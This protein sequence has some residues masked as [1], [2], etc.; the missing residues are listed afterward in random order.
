MFLISVIALCAIPLFWA[1]AA[2]AKLRVLCGSSMA[3]PMKKVVDAF[4]RETGFG[5][6]LT[7]G[8]CEALLPQVELGAPADVF[9]GHAPFAGLLKEKG[10]RADRLVVLGAL[11][12][13]LVVAKGNPKG[14]RGVRDLARADVR[15]GLPDARYSTCG[16][17]FEA[18][19]AK[20]NL[21]DGIRARTV[22]TSRAHQELATTLRTGNVD[23]VIVWNFIAA[24]HRE[25]FEVVPMELSFPSAEVFATV[26]KKAENV[27]AA[28]RLLDYLDTDAAKKVFVD[29]GYGAGDAAATLRLYCAAGVQKPVDELV[30]VFKERHPG[31][32]VEAVYQGS[33]ALLAQMG[34]TKQGD[35]YVAGDEFFMDQARSKGYVAEAE[36]MAVFT[37]VLATPLSNPAQLTS[38]KDL[39]KPG[40]RVGLGEE[41]IAAVGHAARVML[42]RLGLWADVQKN[43]VVTAGTVDQLA[44]QTASGGL[45]ACIIWDATAWQFKDKLKVIER[46]DAGSQVGVPVGVLAF[47]EHKDLAKAFVTLATS[48]E[49]RAVLQKYGFVPARSGQAP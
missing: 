23:A 8:G 49:A 33:G 2:P 39:A 47:S 3:E 31:V 17:M 12:P 18:G 24:M 44:I 32:A 41:K 10:L 27:E 1:E 11:R 9:I 22:Y 45:D 40:T 36:R 26:L 48:S 4:E 20:A 19:A 28:G 29:M 46:G 6:E 35:L 42:E 38:F 37:P 21:L 43:V 13:M 7:L 34:L 16:E 14:I 5:A 25:D 30:A 15:V